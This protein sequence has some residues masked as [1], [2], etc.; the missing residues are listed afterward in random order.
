MSF[1]RKIARRMARLA[2]RRNQIGGLHVQCTGHGKKPWLGDIVCAKCDAIH[3]INDET[4]EHPTIDEHGA[5]SCGAMM[6]PVRNERGA[7]LED[8]PFFGRIACRDCARAGVL[9]S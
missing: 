2:A 5:C 6:F 7:L 8:I 3:L 4:K 9:K 1:R